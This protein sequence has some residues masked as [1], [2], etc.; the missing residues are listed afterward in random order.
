MLF[1]AVEIS[2]SH[3][4]AWRR[5]RNRRTSS[6]FLVSRSL[7]NLAIF[8]SIVNGF[9]RYLLVNIPVHVPLCHPPP[10]LRVFRV[11]NT[12]I[13]ARYEEAGQ[14]CFRNVD[15]FQPVKLGFD[16]LQRNLPKV[17]IDQQEPGEPIIFSFIAF[18]ST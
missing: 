17:L 7:L 3:L 1:S 11:E 16:L 8:S 6:R 4:K 18:H 10:L 5:T 14:I 9:S 15:N 12:I 13:V 2:N